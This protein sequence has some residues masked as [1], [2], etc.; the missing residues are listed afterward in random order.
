MCHITDKYFLLIYCFSY[1]LHMPSFTL[2]NIFLYNQIQVLCLGY[3]VLP[4]SLLTGKYKAVSPPVLFFKTYVFDP[5]GIY[6]YI[7]HEIRVQPDFYL[8]G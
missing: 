3:K 1:N 6:F 2:H 8:D 7:L 5:S 4:A